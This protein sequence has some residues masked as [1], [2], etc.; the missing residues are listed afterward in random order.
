MRY[1]NIG[2]I[3][4]GAIA[5]Y[6]LTEINHKNEYLVKITHILVR[7]KQKYIGLEKK[8]N[9]I[10][11]DDINVL[12]ESP[13]DLIVEAANIEAVKRYLPKV[14]KYKSVVIISVGAFVN[15][16]FLKNIYALAKA[17]K[18]TIYLP[19]G[20]IGG[21]DLIQ[22]ANVSSEIESV[23]LMT[24]KPAATFNEQGLL[25]DK[26]I[27]KGTAAEAI[28]RFP[29]NINVAIIL[30]LA[31][32]GTVETQVEI[33]ASAT[34]LLNEHTIEVKGGFGEMKTTIINQPLASNPNTS[35]LS[36]L[37]I[38]GTIFRIANHIKISI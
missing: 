17:H 20:A 36:A 23:K 3:G 19:S 18:H 4:A 6:L 11:T 13:I 35:Q 5:E 25:K 34:S 14:I 1:I 8:Y 9:V 32:I 10:I 37:S 12:I 27:F 2:L 38:L 28:E 31:G 29:K 22:N 26:L 7:N 16:D 33:I 15:E 21:L 30:S 24:T